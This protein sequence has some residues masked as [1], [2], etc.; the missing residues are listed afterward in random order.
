MVEHTPLH[1]QG[2]VN[3]IFQTISQV[4]LAV[5][6]AL[7]P[8]IVGNIDVAYTVAERK[9]LHDKFQPVFYVMVGFEASALFIMLLLIKAMPHAK[10]MDEPS[11]IESESIEMVTSNSCYKIENDYSVTPSELVSLSS[12]ISSL[13]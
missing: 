1:L 7:V 12:E 5:G 3:G 10:E 8:S 13:S 2:V 9:A 11:Q 4:T 6:N